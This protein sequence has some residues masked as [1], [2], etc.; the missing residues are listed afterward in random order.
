MRQYSSTSLSRFNILAITILAVTN[1]AVASCK[2]SGQPPVQHNLLGEWNWTQSGMGSI[3]IVSSLTSGVQKKIVFKSDGTF[4]LQHN[5][6][7]AAMTRK[8]GY[9]C[10]DH[11][12]PVQSI[13]S[14]PIYSVFRLFVGLAMAAFIA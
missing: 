5:D 2:K 9:G 14:S 13:P 8:K 6:S 10:D 1:F 7:T 4:T 12:D 11:S 3:M